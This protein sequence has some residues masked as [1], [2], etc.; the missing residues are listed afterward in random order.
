MTMAALVDAGADPLMIGELVGRLDLD[1]YALTF[2]DVMRCGV[3]ATQA[4]VVIHADDHDHD[5]PHDHR[6]RD[7]RAISD[8]IDAADL[9]ERVRERAQRTFGLLAEVEGKMHRTPADE[10][11]FHEVGSVD[12]IV[13]AA[14][15]RVAAGK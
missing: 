1:G 11:E 5:H 14:A 2:E 9:P 7:Y 15:R 4:H 12:A 3:A 8:L 6:H 13:D 10:V